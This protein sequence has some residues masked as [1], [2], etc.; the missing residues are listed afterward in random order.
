[1]RLRHLCSL[2]ITVSVLAIGAVA[3]PS[4]TDTMRT[5]NALPAGFFFLQ[6][7]VQDDFGAH[8]F[9]VMDVE[10][11]DHK[12]TGLVQ[13]NQPNMRDSQLWKERFPAS[14]SIDVIKLQNKLTGQCLA[15]E[16]TGDGK[17]PIRPCD[18]E[19]TKWQKIPQGN[20]NKVVL[21]RLAVHNT[22]LF[23]DFKVC[24]MKDS[25]VPGFVVILTC[26]ADTFPGEMVWLATLKPL[27]TSTSASTPATPPPSPPSAP[28]NCKLFGSG[29]TCGLVGFNCDPFSAADT[30]VVGSGIIGVHVTAVEPKLG[31]VTGTYQNEGKA[32][33]AV[34]AMKSG[35]TSCGGPIDATF[36]P[37]LCA[38]SGATPIFSCPHGQIHCST[39]CRPASDPECHPK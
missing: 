10:N 16:E 34:C 24:V 39:G 3:L 37:T 4:L 30:I 32:S 35:L 29:G 18:H 2:V 9:G 38:G 12:V 27:G 31:I 13:L 17:A 15:D 26:N 7:S 8:A 33:V 20:A 36:G 25:R 14:G 22:G 5:A 19:S 1:M 28:T 11:A 6:G 21:R 23:P